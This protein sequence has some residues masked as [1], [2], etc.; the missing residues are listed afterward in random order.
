VQ[1][2]EPTGCPIPRSHQVEFLWS[3]RVNLINNQHNLYNPRGQ[4]PTGNLTREIDTTPPAAKIGGCKDQ[5]TFKRPAQGLEGFG[6]GLG[7]C[8]KHEGGDVIICE[9][10]NISFV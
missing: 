9:L 7:V 10:R 4:K 5:S 1:Q 8:T 6:F 2:V 3:N